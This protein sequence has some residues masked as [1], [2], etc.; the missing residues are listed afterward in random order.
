M[1]TI[2]YALAIIILS[3][4]HHWNN[5][6]AQKP[7]KVV[8]H[9]EKSTRTFKEVSGDPLKVKEYTL[10]NGLKIY[11]SPNQSEPRIQTLVLVKAGSI[12]DPADATGLAHYL[13]HMLFKGND[14]MGTINY[15]KEKLQLDKIKA[16]FED[17]KASTDTTDRLRIYHEIDSISG[18]AAQYACP[19]E[20]TQMFSQ[21]GAKGTNAYTSKEFTGYINDIPSNQL[22]NWLHIESARYTNP[23]LRL[24]HTELEAV[25]EEK[26]ITLDKADRRMYEIFSKAIYPN[27][28]YGKQTTIGTV[29]HLKSPSMEAIEKFF[30]TYYVPNN[31]A[32]FLAGDVNPDS[33][34]TL[35][36]KQ[37]GHFEAKEVPTYKYDIS[38]QF[39]EPQIA[40]MTSKEA[41]QLMIGF[42]FPGAG[43]KESYM[44]ELVDMLLNNRTAGLFDININQAQ[45]AV[46]AYSYPYVLKDYSTHVMG[47][48]PNKGQSLEE[49]KQLIFDQL[50]ELKKGN[51]KDWMLQ[52]VVNDLKKSEIMQA[53]SNNHRVSA[54]SNAFAKNIPWEIETK[55]FEKLSAITKEEIVD[56]VNTYYKEN[57]VAVYRTQSDSV[58]NQQVEKPEITPIDIPKE[59][60]SD[61]L[62]EFSK[63]KGP[64]AIDPVFVKYLDQINLS[65]IDTNRNLF[66]QKNT[67]D[68]LFS[69]SFVI[70]VG[71]N[72]NPN[73]SLAFSYAELCGSTHMSLSELNEQW[74]KLGIDFSIGVGEEE[75]HLTLTGLSS[76][77]TKGINLMKDYLA[78]IAPDSAQ[79]IALK[80]KSIQLRENSLTN[81]RHILWT[82]L[83]N[84]LV[85]GEKSPYMSALSNDEL[86]S[87]TSIDLLELFVASI[88]KVNEVYYYGPL[89]RRKIFKLVPDL[90]KSI[91]SNFTLNTFS[92]LD[93]KSENEIFFLD[94]E[95]QQAEI[96]MMHKSAQF[97]KEQLP[98]L[99]LFN[100][101]FGG[102]MSSIV[103]QEIREK[104]AL[105]YSVYAGYSRTK[106]SDDPH[107][108][109]AYIGTQAD[110]YP[111][112]MRAMLNIL[113][114][115]PY[116]SL[117]FAQAKE[118]IKQKYATNRIAEHGM[119]GAYR[120]DKKLGYTY[121]KRKDSFE[122][123]D[124]LTFN[125]VEH[126]FQKFIKGNKYRI[127]VLGDAKKIDLK[128]LSTFGTVKQVEFKDIFP[129]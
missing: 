103:F 39:N 23:V 67:Q 107:Y 109:M 101:Y 56:F 44:I 113:E 64:K 77:M 57:Y 93:T 18:I 52:A 3:S 25:Y 14:K 75:S 102:G 68:S 129:Y 81:K 79:L 72:H 10:E 59:N 53:R 20:I 117:K 32:I 124:K 8:N 49:L 19:N 118:A 26:N 47:G 31:M 12:H 33:A 92:R 80:N 86:Q 123:I 38:H 111:E 50:N 51:F 17:L 35:I 15:E 127:A 116:D 122:Q 46:N 66:Y 6:Q 36:E 69:L 43:T 106:K 94:F 11:I 28:N 41:E 120:T 42:R 21:I 89:P 98:V 13:E 114:K 128:T 48:T 125:E 88:S 100:E 1:R 104:Q 34:V 65:K 45:K 62:L 91:Q 2:T 22:E 95:M 85:Y 61:F 24:F 96:L 7:A 105:A 54:M 108:T 70:P 16:L 71:S 84:Y 110:K 126:F 121:D 4:C 5:V 40:K 63:R 87:K 9:Y 37:F 83:K 60:R 74:Y 29:A 55:H 90:S 78:H 73:L 82:G 30:K 99:T 97:S 119:M 112:A 27:H 115:L 58:K 76:N